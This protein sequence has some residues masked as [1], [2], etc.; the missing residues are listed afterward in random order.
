MPTEIGQ[1]VPTAGLSGTRHPRGIRSHPRDASLYQFPFNFLREPAGIP[2]FDHDHSI[3]AF[4]DL[5]E[6]D[7]ECLHVEAELRRQL[8]EPYLEFRSQAR[9]FIREDFQNFIAADQGPI[10]SDFF[11]ELHR[12][13]KVIRHRT[14]PALVSLRFVPSSERGIDLDGI[15]TLRIAF[16]MST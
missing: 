11:R 8:N 6:K 1:T 3:A 15:Q 7:F 14:R 10:M 9:S 13:F 12:E 5:F 4:I 2:R 16:E